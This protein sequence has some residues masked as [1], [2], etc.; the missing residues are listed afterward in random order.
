MKIQTKMLAAFAA[1]ATVATMATPAAAVQNIYL[2]Y[3][4]MNTTFQ[5]NISGSAT[6]IRTA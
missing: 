5:A 3:A 4:T 2:E 1:A 6:S